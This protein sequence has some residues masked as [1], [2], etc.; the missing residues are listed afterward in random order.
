MM[1]CTAQENAP[2]KTADLVTSVSLVAD[3]AQFSK[4]TNVKNASVTIRTQDRPVLLS[5]VPISNATDRPYHI[6]LDSPMGDVTNRWELRYMR[7]FVVPIAVFAVGQTTPS[8]SSTV[9]VPLN[10]TALDTPSAGSHTYILQIR[11]VGSQTKADSPKLEIQNARI[12]AT[13]L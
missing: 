10:L 4:W 5:L 8:H 1:W 13:T 6:T 3:A 9:D 12:S 7:D 11:Y 2:R